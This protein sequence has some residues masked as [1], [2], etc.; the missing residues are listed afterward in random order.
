MR[1]TALLIDWGGVLEDP[2]DPPLGSAALIDVV[3]W[4]RVTGVRVAVVSNS[5]SASPFAAERFDAVVV[6]GEVGYAKPAPEIYRVA[7][8]RLER[9][10]EECV[11]VDDLHDNVAAAVRLG[12]VGVHHRDVASTNT[13]LAALFGVPVDH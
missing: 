4:L 11:L 7:A 1:L 2:G 3:S 12:M 13:E 5:P 6:S 8:E 9:P 10:I